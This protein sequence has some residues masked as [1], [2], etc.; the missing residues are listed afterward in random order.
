MLPITMILHL[1]AT[2]AHGLGNG[3]RLDDGGVG[4]I[5]E[6]GLKKGFNNIN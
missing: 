4:R 3:R 1:D 6:A 2:V 5:V